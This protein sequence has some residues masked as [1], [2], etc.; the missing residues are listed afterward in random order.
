MSV[1]NIN[2][3]IAHLIE[4]LQQEL[5]EQIF[6]RKWFERIITIQYLVAKK[7]F[8]L[9][10]YDEV[11]ILKLCEQENSHFVD[12]FE[13]DLE[14]LKKHFPH[15]FFDETTI[16]LLNY[17]IN[18]TTKI[19]ELI[20]YQENFQ[21]Y[22]RFSH[23]KYTNRNPNIE[24]NQNN[25]SMVTQIFTPKWIAK[26]MAQNVLFDTKAQYLLSTNKKNQ[27]C[28][29]TCKILDPCLGMGK[30][31]LEVLDILL[32]KYQKENQNLD[33]KTIIAHIY[34]NQL[35]GF[36]IDQNV[37]HLA[38]FIFMMKAFELCPNYING[39]IILPNFMCITTPKIKSSLH[40]A[41]CDLIHHL[42]NAS[43]LGSL[44]KMPNYDYEKLLTEV[45]LPEEQSIIRLASLLHMKYD[46]VLT[47]P[48]YMGRKMLPTIV[49]EYL[50]KNYLYAKSELYTAFIIRC[51]DFLV[52]GG[53]MAML[54]LHTWMFIKSFSE[55]RRYILTHFQIMSLLHLGK[56]TFKNL[57]AY[58]AL[59]SAFVI[60][61]TLPNKKSIF[62]RLTDYPDIDAKEQA[63]FNQDNYFVL[64][65]K[66]FLKLNTFPFIYWLDENEY[67][68]LIR[69]PKLGV[70]GNIRQ[71]LATGDNKKFIRWW[72]EVEPKEI[73]FGYN[74]IEVFL[75]S[76]KKYAPYNKGGDQTKWYATSK[77][78]IRFDQE[79]YN[80]LQKQG[81]HL[82]SKE[83]YFKAGITWSLFGFNSF[84]VR[85]KEAGYVFDVSGS[86]LFSKKEL[87]KYILGY[88]SSDV[89]F[90]FLSSIAP[91]VN[92]Q[93]GNIAS[94]PFILDESK[95]AEVNDIVSRL[96]DYAKLLDS[97]DELSWNYIQDA[98]FVNYNSNVSFMKNIEFYLDKRNRIDEAMQEEEIKLNEI[99]NA[100]FKVR[101]P[102]RNKKQKEI[103]PK[104]I[105]ENLLSYAMGVVF[106]RYQIKEYSNCLDLKKFQDI[107]IITKE[108][109]K[110]L[111]NKL[112]DTSIEEL[113]KELG[114]SIDEYFKNY[115]GKRHITKYHH[116][117]LYWYKVEND[118]QYIGYY[119][120]LEKIDK[121][122]GIR[123]NYMQNT[124]Q[125][126]IK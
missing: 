35:Y 72:Y 62:V 39:K 51:L 34:Q 104:D 86:S 37:I 126:K 73:G 28:Y 15:H 30:L 74:S 12:V 58:N 87:E 22:E 42:E 124:L 114:Y 80:I 4:R 59:T 54:S 115:F 66:R 48:P 63:F 32:A 46:I 95:V 23:F 79:A 10:K 36:D 88:L 116:L 70:N 121:D 57:N 49:L 7:I 99:Y 122:K 69:Q 81:N 90:F 100:I 19:E 98:F 65:T 26:Y 17:Y 43:I 118:K 123:Y 45:T 55:L 101:I 93:V 112:S 18:V 2:P 60:Q 31:L 52:P 50:N 84:N 77:V 27:I 21:D 38:K 97:Y 71:G 8:K 117:P 120:T 16:N 91:T 41:V 11:N 111:Q 68:I 33:L 113:E 40:S 105:I 61:K 107:Y 83:Y 64:D 119:H 110:V 89:A 75:Q 108:I 9:E 109:K 47:N 94:L 44:I 76:H 25:I 106:N 125:Y 102:H 3:F 96:I 78:V 103:L 1:T 20:A 13:D 92:F 56:N 14:E 24:V 85:Y 5:D 53:Y 82:P 67:D 29:Q 6:V